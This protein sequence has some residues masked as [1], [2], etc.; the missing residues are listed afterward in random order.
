MRAQAIAGVRNMRRLWMAISVAAAHACFAK[1]TTVR[2]YTTRF[3]RTPKA[4]SAPASAAFRAHLP[5]PHRMLG[6]SATVEARAAKRQ[7]QDTSTGTRAVA[8]P[9]SRKR[10]PP[11]DHDTGDVPRRHEKQ[12]RRASAVSNSR[13]GSHQLRTAGVQSGAGAGSDEAKTEGDTS[14][15]ARGKPGRC[16]CLLPGKPVRNYLSPCIVASVLFSQWVEAF[17]EAQYKRRSVTP[18]RGCNLR[19]GHRV[20]ETSSCCFCRFVSGHGTP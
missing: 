10:K 15:A 17:H 3:D 13:R 18:R 8:P 9:T 14:T 1:P 5:Q 4:S 2:H 7:L 20:P 19:R 16:K 11:P 12:Q 6:R